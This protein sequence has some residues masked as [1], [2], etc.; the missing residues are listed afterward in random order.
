[1]KS[2]GLWI[3]VTWAV[4]A[5]GALAKDLPDPASETVG[6]LTV[7]IREL[8]VHAGQQGFPELSP[9]L[10]WIVGVLL[11]NTGD[12][13][14]RGTLRVYGVDGWRVEPSAPQPFTLE[15]NEADPE[16]GYEGTYYD[17]LLESKNKKVMRFMVTIPEGAYDA[18]YPIHAYVEF[19]YKGRRE[20][21][22]P[23]LVVETRFPDRPRLASPIEWKP[24]A[25]PGKGGMALWRLPVHRDKAE[26]A[27][28]LPAVVR[29]P[30]THVIGDN[31]DYGVRVQR[32][33]SRECVSM[34]LGMKAPSFST[35]V[36]KVIAE[37]PLELP[38]THSIQLR[39]A[40]AVRDPNPKGGPASPEDVTFRVRA[41]PFDAPPDSSGRVVFERRTDAKVWQDAV[42]DLS[43]F[44]GQRIRLQLEAGSLPE[45]RAGRQADWAEPTVVTD[46]PP[47][48]AA[49]PPP[50]NAP[51]R[52]LGTIERQGKQYEVRVWPGQRGMLDAAV[53]LKSAQAHLMFHG[54]RIRIL[55]D[56]LGTWNSV[57][58]LLEAREETAAR[59]RY[60]VRHRFAS[61][62][63]PFDLVGEMWTE[64]GALWTHFWLENAPAPRP[65]FHMYLED[66]AA[67]PWNERATQVYMGD[68]NVLRDPAAFSLR[69]GGYDL[70]TSFIGIDFSNGLSLVQGVDV[71]P[72]NA[73]VDPGS[74]TYT[75]HTADNPTLTFIPA[76]NVW[77]GVR[78][79]HDVNGLKAACGVA[80]KAGRFVFDFWVNGGTYAECARNLTRAFHY[81]LTDAIVVHHNWQRRG[82]ADRLPDEYPP[83]PF[84][85]T[86]EEFQ[87][88][89]NTCRRA[90]VLFAPHDN[91][92]NFYPDADGFTFDDIAFL[93]DGRP[94]KGALGGR[95]VTHQSYMF[96][97]DKVLPFM[98][99]NLAILRESFAPT[100]YFIDDWTAIGPYDYWTKDGEFHDRTTTRKDIGEAFAWVRNYLGNNA[101]AISEAGHDQYI[102]YFDGGDCQF[103]GLQ[104]GLPAY[105]GWTMK[106]ADS[107]RTPWFDAAHHDRFILHGAGYTDR[108]APGLDPRSHG[109]YS[110]DYI[111][112]EVL[113]GH[114]AL[115]TQPF[116][117]DVVRKYWLLHDLMRALALKRIDG[118]EYAGGNLHR[119]LVRWEG[120]SEVWV[121][122]GSSEWNVAGH[123][124]PEYGYYAR[125]QDRG[126]TVESAV[127]RL[128]GVIVE[129]SRSPS[130]WYV[131]ARPVNPRQLDE[132]GSEV[133]VLPP[134]LSGTDPRLARMNLEKKAIAFG[135]L[136]TDGGFRL[137]REGDTVTVTALPTGSAFQVRLVW[138]DLPWKLTQPKQ[139]EALDESGQVIRS[140]PLQ[141]AGGEIILAYDPEV[142][143]YRLQAGIR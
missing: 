56:E 50:A 61:W 87:N 136:T 15:K 69:F 43:P 140:V 96:R 65:W 80:T 113:A 112:T 86:V 23:V 141:E 20:V 48:A 62:A 130:L 47:A 100:A 124:L 94:R 14:L 63:G 38:K 79:W 58:T 102:G 24:V 64:K 53:D 25:V 125:V 110:D 35:R 75:I 73:E 6:P 2:N 121:N 115:V 66:V 67:G 105:R 46:A 54:F 143:G 49:F 16:K 103:Q 77:D 142:F 55:G 109:P 13:P 52:L 39:F 133:F 37:Y 21:V 11:R 9:G 18:D 99:R 32:G 76:A 71:A 27:E 107:E 118:V 30:E 74:R 137:A 135:P 31:V 40:I 7:G 22:H 41:L 85:G 95:E 1:M 129:W 122:R 33:T 26:I 89:V 101:P 97:A 91:Y 82:A 4:L 111:A 34:G 78:V 45:S 138:K 44:A 12:T 60:R 19:E 8:S 117:R 88:L 127:E 106:C 83:N 128:G 84:L 132:L 10:P 114:P 51:S 42:A 81:G 139:A 93:A 119:Q 70:S 92:I 29:T 126:T 131:N 123:V 59:P 5:T 3:A 98:Q 104:A 90:G 72:N 116:G 134:A 108:Y 68:G 17:Y 57:S 36:D 28:G 120:G